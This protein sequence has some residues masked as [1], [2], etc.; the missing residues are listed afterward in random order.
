MEILINIDV[1]DMEAA[2]RFYTKACNLQIGRR[3]DEGFV[4]L[5]GAGANIYLLQND[6]GTAA[7]KTGET[8]NYERH[9]CP[10][11]LDFAVADIEIAVA[12][13]LAEGASIEIPLQER[14]YGKLVV[15]ADPFGNGFCFIQFTGEGYNA[16]KK[17]DNQTP[18]KTFGSFN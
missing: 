14:P 1:P 4:E 8:R 3:F 18:P 2:V 7:T 15:L 12:H 11:H 5:L 6:A 16:M 13:A 10:I 17:L 9:W